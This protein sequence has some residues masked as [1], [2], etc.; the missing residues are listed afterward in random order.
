MSEPVIT[1]RAKAEP[2][3]TEAISSSA[4]FM[5][6][7]FEDSGS[8]H[9]LEQDAEGVKVLEG[10]RVTKLQPIAFVR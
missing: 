10:N 1:P 7:E 9:G 8:K 4:S 6:L 2:S 3:E 5:V